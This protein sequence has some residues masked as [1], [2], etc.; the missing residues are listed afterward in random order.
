MRSSSEQH[1]LLFLNCFSD[2]INQAAPSTM[3]RGQEYLESAWLHIQQHLSSSEQ[4][5]S[6]GHSSSC[7][8]PPRTQ[9]KKIIMK[10]ICPG[11]SESPWLE[12][13]PASVTLHLSGFR[14]ILMGLRLMTQLFSP[15]F[16]LA[17]THQEV[18][19][20]CMHQRVWLKSK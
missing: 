1:L 7:I 15:A 12:E 16:A 10:T 17:V 20:I 19:E 5:N 4:N 11:D 18:T 2:P 14:S 6:L 3:M 9:L 8:S 13:S